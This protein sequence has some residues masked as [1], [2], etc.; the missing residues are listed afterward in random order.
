MFPKSTV[1][2]Y[3]EVKNKMLKIYLVNNNLF[4][5]TYKYN[6]TYSKLYP[7]QDLPIVKS[8]K[9]KKKKLIAEFLIMPGKYSLKNQY[10]WVLGNK[11]VFH[12]NKYKYRQ[13]YNCNLNIHKQQST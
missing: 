11:N 4:D 5:I 6:A 2:T 7:M 12:S 10:S 13:Y 8:I 3:S 9:A 1:Y